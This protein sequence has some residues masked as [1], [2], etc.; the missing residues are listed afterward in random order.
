MKTQ[1]RPARPLA[2]GEIMATTT[3]PS[4]EAVPM[5][6][7]GKWTELKAKRSGDVYNP[8]TGKVIGR[9]GYATA[10]ETGRVVEAAAAALPA[11]SATPVVERARLMF[12]FRAILEQ[13][14]EELAALVTREHGKTLAE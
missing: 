4:I 1:R 3:A 2:E 7:N 13:N 10:E 6:S 5:L 9:V 11:W 12:R 14:F 8:S